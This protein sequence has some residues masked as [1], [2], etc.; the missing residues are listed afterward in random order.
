MCKAHAGHFS[1]ERTFLGP[2]LRKDIYR[3]MATTQSFMDQ[4]LAQRAC[5]PL[6]KPPGLHL[7]ARHGCHAACWLAAAALSCLL[8]HCACLSPDISVYACTA[9]APDF[10]VSISALKKVRPGCCKHFIPLQHNSLAPYSRCGAAAT[11]FLSS[12]ADCRAPSSPSIP[13]AN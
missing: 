2:A 12:V 9:T 1:G 3:S 5:L 8:Y 10:H 6:C 13:L 7:A 4:R 11:H